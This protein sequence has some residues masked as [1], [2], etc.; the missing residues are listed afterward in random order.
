MEVDGGINNSTIELVSDAG[1]NV[2]VAGSSI[3]E[4]DNITAAVTE[5]KQKI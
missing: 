4:T 1:C 2:F 5:L 3:F